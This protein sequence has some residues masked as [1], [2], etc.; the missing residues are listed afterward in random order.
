VALTCYFM[1]GFGYPQGMGLADVKLAG[2]VGGM[3][4]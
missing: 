1:L 3:L 2:L 4:A